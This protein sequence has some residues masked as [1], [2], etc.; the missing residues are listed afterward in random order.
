MTPQ[1]HISLFSVTINLHLYLQVLKYLKPGPVR[2]SCRERVPRAALASNKVL[3]KRTAQFIS[4]CVDPNN[5][6]NIILWKI[7][8]QKRIKPNIQTEVC[9]MYKSSTECYNS[10]LLSKL[11]LL[12]TLNTGKIRRKNGKTLSSY[13]TVQYKHL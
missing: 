3:L 7:S 8:I 1:I 2:Y 11:F 9:N 13:F 10:H 4:F 12:A 6:S 5:K